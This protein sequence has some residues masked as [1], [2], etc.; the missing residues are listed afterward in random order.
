MGHQHAIVRGESYRYGRNLGGNEREAMEG[1]EGQFSYAFPQPNEDFINGAT[2]RFKA[3]GGDEGSELSFEQAVPCIW[4]L[5]VALGAPKP[6]SEEEALAKILE[7]FA[8]IDEDGSGTI[9]LEE[10]GKA[11][12]LATGVVMIGLGAAAC[13]A[14]GVSLD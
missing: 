13:E 10:F 4:E 2:E 5:G 7:A 8:E 14:N 3:A 9:S 6:A 12:W 1:L 11:G